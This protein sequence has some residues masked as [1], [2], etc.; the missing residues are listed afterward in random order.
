MARLNPVELYQ[1]GIIQIG[2]FADGGQISPIRLQFELLPSYPVLLGK[3]GTLVAEILGKHK[4]INRII[5]DQHSAALGAIVSTTLQMPMVY[6]AGQDMIGAYDVGHPASLLVNEIDPA[7]VE[8]IIRHAERVGLEVRMI[9]TLSAGQLPIPGIDVFSVFQKE[10][11]LAA[12]AG[13][14]SQLAAVRKYLTDRAV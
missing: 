4:A 13:S 11:L 6:Y 14:G 8:Q 2:Y 12:L 1:A 3:V 9:I 5:T 7:K 10:Q